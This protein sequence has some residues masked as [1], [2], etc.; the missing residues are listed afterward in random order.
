MVNKCVN[1]KRQQE[2]VDFVTRVVILTIFGETN[3]T[4]T[5]DNS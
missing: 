4:N 1:I 5:L 3:H 2:A